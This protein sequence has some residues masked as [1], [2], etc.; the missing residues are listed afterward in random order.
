MV[1]EIPLCCTLQFF[2]LR[3]FVAHCDAVLWTE[4]GPRACVCVCLCRVRFKCILYVDESLL[5]YTL[6]DPNCFSTWIALVSLFSFISVACVDFCLH[7]F[8]ILVH[9]LFCLIIF[10]CCCIWLHLFLSPGIVLQRTLLF[11]VQNIISMLWL[12]LASE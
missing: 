4:P 3:S 7:C 8:H 1:E 11:H 10:F 2:T 6:K 9:R 12:I 5:C